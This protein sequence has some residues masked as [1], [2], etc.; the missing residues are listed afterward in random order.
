MCV[1]STTNYFI[2]DGTKKQ[3]EKEREVREYFILTGRQVLELPE[4]CGR[5]FSQIS[6]HSSEV[7]SAEAPHTPPISSQM[8]GGDPVPVSGIS[9]FSAGS[10]DKL[11]LPASG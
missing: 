5:Q 3:T 10:Q 7:S 9:Q 11:C 4:L 6:H 1:V 2:P 8:W